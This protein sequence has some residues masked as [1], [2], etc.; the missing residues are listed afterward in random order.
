MK[1]VK[2]DLDAIEPKV[3]ETDKDEGEEEADDLADLLGGL[4]VKES[5]CELC[6][7]LYVFWI[8]RR[9]RPGLKSRPFD[10]F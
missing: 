4:T 5:R 1:N 10:C 8:R 6:D 2:N 9:V 3:K 7:D